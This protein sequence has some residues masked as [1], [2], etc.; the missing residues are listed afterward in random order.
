MIPTSADQ[1]TNSF[2]NPASPATY[3]SEFNHPSSYPSQLQSGVT[4][5]SDPIGAELKS[6]YGTS[7][8]YAMHWLAD[9]R[10]QVRVRRDARCGLR[11]RPDGDGTSYIN[12]FQRGPAGVGL[13][14]HPAA[15]VRGVQVR[16]HQRLP[17]PVSPRTRRTPSS[18]STPTPPT[19]TARS[20]EAVYWANQW[21]T[22]QGKQA[23]VAGTVAKAAKMGDYLRYS[24]FDKYFKT[25]G[26]TSPS[27]PRARA[28][29]A[30]TTCCPGT[31][32]GVARSTRRP[33]GPGASGRRTRTSG[34]RTRWP[35]GCCRATRP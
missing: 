22:A 24:L 5:G 31:T 20:I 8:I 12:T 28:A 16:R 9:V 1:P 33:A 11:A 23:D 30:S 3:A 19:R 4:S 26:C 7:D 34:T 2:Y 15:V 25:I 27:C 32:P 13:G 6:T 29:A 21:A 10:Q 35:R 17:R 18:G 14:D